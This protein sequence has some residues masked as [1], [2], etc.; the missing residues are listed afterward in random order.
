MTVSARRLANAVWRTGELPAELPP[1][2]NK[3]VRCTGGG[4]VGK[5]MDVVLDD[6]SGTILFCVVSFGSMPHFG[7]DCRVVPF[8]VVQL[9]SKTGHV[10][11]TLD[12]ETLRDAPIFLPGHE[13]M[14]E[15]WWKRVEDYYRGFRH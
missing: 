7:D 1:C 13:A 2:M 11:V 15:N 6:S 14:D 9:D 12:P 4:T 3:P 8:D 10:V 5:I